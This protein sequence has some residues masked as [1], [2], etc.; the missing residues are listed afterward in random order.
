MIEPFGKRMKRIRKERKITQ[1]ELE[2]STGL[3][4]GTISKYET[5]E[6]EPK[7]SRIEWICKALGVSA[8][9]LLGY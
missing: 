4:K 8:S 7:I 6:I 1:R 5:G 9:E 2:I 3:C